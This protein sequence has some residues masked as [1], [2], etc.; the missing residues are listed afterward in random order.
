MTDSPLLHVED[1][2]VDVVIGDTPYRAIDHLSFSVRSGEAMGLV[3]ESGSGKS[4]TLRALLGLLPD[5]AHVTKGSVTLDG[6]DLLHGDRGGY[7]DSIRGTGISMVFQEPAVALNPIA[8]VGEQIS[9]VLQER[10]SLSKS[11]SRQK[12]IELLDKVGIVQPEKRV[13]SYPFELSGGMRQ[14]VMIA[15]AVACHPKVLLCDEPTTA[16]DVTIQAQIIDLFNTLRAEDNIALLYVTHDLA[17]V[18][19]ICDSITVLYGGQAMEHGGLRQVFNQPTHPYTAALLE[20]TPRLDGPRGRLKT[21]P[22]SAPMLTDRGNGCPFAGRCQFAT[23]IC[24]T[25]AFY[26]LHPTPHPTQQSACVRV[27]DQG[28]VLEE[29]PVLR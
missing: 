11:A 26:A 9:D 15:A 20:S 14:R 28:S 1:L 12:A 23:D 13:D 21:I 17:V 3:G 5:N 6:V 24:M 27:N 25:D 29:E 16:L 2:C 19:Q 8:T 22:G 10:E 18:S 4:L 7:L